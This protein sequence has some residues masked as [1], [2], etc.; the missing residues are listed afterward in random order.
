ME[1]K[2]LFLDTNILL[3]ELFEDRIFSKATAKKIDSFIKDGY[4]FVLNALSLNTIWY[5]GAKKD[6]LKTL[7]FIKDFFKTDLFEVYEIK[8]RDIIEIIS[9]ID[10]NP[11]ADFEDLQQYICA[12]NSNSIAI[13]TNDKN[14]PKIDLPLIRTENFD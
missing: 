3:D 14:F 12:K 10:K 5:I 2:K 1:N 6:R 11:K 4:T 13:I 9:I 7:E 8:N